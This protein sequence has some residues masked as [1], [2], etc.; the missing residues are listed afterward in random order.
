[1]Y[2]WVN[3]VNVAVWLKFDCS[4]SYISFQQHVHRQK[5]IVM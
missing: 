4:T 2:I 3:R 5:L 1:M